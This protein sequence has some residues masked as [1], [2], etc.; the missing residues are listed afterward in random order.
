MIYLLVFFT[1]LIT[2]IFLTPFYIKFLNRTKI[3][4]KPGGRKIHTEII[5][6]MG[7]LIIFFVV[8]IMLNAFIEDFNS[9]KLII[10]SATL[11]VFSGI[12]DD[13]VGL[14][15]FIKFVVQNISAIILVYYLEQQYTYVKIFG[16]ILSSPFDYLIL[17]LFII[18]TINSINFLDGLDGLATGFS[19]LIFSV[20]LALAIRKNDVFL[21]LMNVT[22]L[23]STIGFLRFNAF[24]ASVFLGDT[25]S[26]IL[27]FFLVLLSSLTSINYHESALDLTFPLILLAV[28]IVDTIKVFLIRIIK[29]RDPFSGDTIHQHHIL[30]ISIVSHE[31]TVFIIELFSLFF[32][33]LSLI[34]LIDYRLEATILYF[35]FGSVLILI[36][37]LLIKFNIARG[38][39]KSLI[40]IHNFPIKNLFFL[41]KLLLIISTILVVAISVRWY[42]CFFKFFNIFYCLKVKFTFSLYR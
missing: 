29:K 40:L 15:N 28:P 24:P 25:G 11:L 38:I 39:N 32:I 13:V 5:P 16:F 10:I 6:R 37:P 35:F 3:V 18:G 36:Q 7:G 19:I 4:D 9:I 27:G 1:S 23:G 33:L 30:K 2:T 8:I 17:L 34:Y 20:L 22:L 12:I 26:L 41:I 42:K 14:D 31:A 21:I